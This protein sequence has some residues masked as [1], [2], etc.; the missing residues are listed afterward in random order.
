LLQSYNYYAIISIYICNAGNLKGTAGFGMGKGKGPR[1][2]INAAFR[3]GMRNLLHIDLYDNF[4]LAHDLHGKHNSCHA[5]IRATPRSRD[6]VASDFA[7]EIL[8]R[9]G[10]GSASVKLVGRRT[11]YSQVRAIFDALSK[12]EN[13]DEYAKM[14]GKRYLTLKWAKENNL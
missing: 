3:D 10:I 2:A 12:H 6:M 5:Y 7:S 11:P 1:E 4:G 13:I 14:T 9:F 8:L